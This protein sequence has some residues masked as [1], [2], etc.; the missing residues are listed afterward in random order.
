MS[1]RLL[2]SLVV[3]AIVDVTLLGDEAFTEKMYDYY[4]VNFS[5]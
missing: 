1:N 5:Y 2:A 4:D 3:D